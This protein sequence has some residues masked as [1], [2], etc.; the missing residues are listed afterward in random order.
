MKRS[1]NQ[2]LSPI[3]ALF[4][5]LFMWGSHLLPKYP[6]V[7]VD[8]DVVPY[9]LGGLFTLL[10]VLLFFVKD[11]NEGIEAM[12]AKIQEESR[13]ES[14][15][16]NGG[17][18]EEESTLETIS[19]GKSIVDLPLKSEE[20]P[21]L[22]QV[23]RRHQL[24][25]LALETWQILLFVVAIL[26]YIALLESIGFFIMTALFLFSTTALLGYKH[27]WRNAIVALAVPLFFYLT[28]TQLLKI[29][30]PSGILPF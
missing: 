13:E 23:V 8:A 19:S 3:L 6:L 18:N 16:E 2:I 9:F 4:G 10:A 25:G 14:R 17:K 28:F 11:S 7:P 5:L 27:Y 30:L 26:L 24:W 29:S 22:K 1:V 15:E 12:S 21:Q 20:R